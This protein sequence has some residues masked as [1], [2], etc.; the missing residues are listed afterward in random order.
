VGVTPPD[1][2][3]RVGSVELPNPVMTASGTSGY[4]AELAP[5]GRLGALGA[6]VVKSLAADPWP[7]NPAPRVTEVGQ[8]MLNSVGLA[9]PGLPAWLETELPRLSA[10]QARV[11]VSIWG[12]RVSDFERVAR[13][14]APVGATV[15]A[16]EVNVSCPNLEDRSRMFA[17]SASATAEAVEAA[18]CGK[19][20]WA[21]L[22][23]AVADLT[24]IAAGALAGGAEALT[25]VNT[26][27]GLSIDVE[28]RRPSLGAGAGGL[29]G[30][31]L[32]PV[33]L[34]AVWEV[35]N[36]FSD[37]P[38]VGVGG[39]TS[40]REAIEFL[41]AGADAVQVGTAIFRDPRA[42]WRILAEIDRWCRRH[43]VGAVRDLVG[44]AQ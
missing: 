17:Q 1:L 16:V 36:A 34:R 15:V 27:P 20:R 25:L 4:G 10:L 29:S 19:P 30:M 41:M 2:R 39:V 12:Q 3:T 6:V 11:V 8:G 42:P 21:K 18:R 13:L 24:E 9:G 37:T 33:A 44:V 38:I 23:A 32:H 26:L 5:Y 7:G 35:R 40:G 43:H 14:L 22:S 31:P 28:R